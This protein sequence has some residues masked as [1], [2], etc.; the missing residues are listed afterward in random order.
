MKQIYNAIIYVPVDLSEGKVLKEIIID[1]NGKISYQ[2]KE[3]KVLRG[4]APS[5]Y[6]FQEIA[7]ENENARYV[8]VSK[9]VVGENAHLNLPIAI[10]EI[11]NLVSWLSFIT[12][13][14]CRIIRWGSIDEISESGSIKVGYKFNIPSDNL[15]EPLIDE[16]D[17]IMQSYKIDSKIIPNFEKFLEVDL[18]DQVK[19]ILRWYKKGNQSLFPEEKLIFWVTALEGIS[20]ALHVDGNREEKCIC[21]HTV[22]IRDS[23]NKI[24]LLKFI[25][26]LDSNYSRTKIY[27]PIWSARSKYVHA[28]NPKFDYFSEEMNSVLNATKSLLIG[29]FSYYLF[30]EKCVPFIDYDTKFF[31]HPLIGDISS[32][33]VD[34]D[35]FIS[36]GIYKKYLK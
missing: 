10:S 27:E 8:N 14:D 31:N 13:V 3:K 4:L 24:A 23:A 28:A 5:P 35:N 21:G 30:I 16:R 1:E 6:I 18:T 15:P 19:A 36:T 20:G 34:I 29:F 25:K 12:L 11:E 33:K 26:E 7:K 17:G 2:V 22:E 9:T 32:L